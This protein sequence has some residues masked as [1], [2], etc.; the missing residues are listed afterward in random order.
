[1]NDRRALSKVSEELSQG[2][3]GTRELEP[4]TNEIGYDSLNEVIK[5]AALLMSCVYTDRSP[6][7]IQLGKINL[8]TTR[9]ASFGPL[10]MTNISKASPIFAS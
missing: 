5:V 1:M 9:I 2:H 7:P 3:T 10:S 6:I 8:H 4:A